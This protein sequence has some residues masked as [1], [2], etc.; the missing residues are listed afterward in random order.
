ME[1]SYLTYLNGV[2]IAELALTD[3]ETLQAIESSLAAQGR[4]SCVI[5]PRVHLAPKAGVDGHFN[6]LRG[7]IGA[8]M[9][10]AGVKVV[11]DF[12]DNYKLGLPSELGMLNLFDPR[13]GV[14]I[15]IV[16]AT[17]ITDMR[18]GAI[19]ALGAKHLARKNSKILG[20]V[21]ARGTAYWNVRLLDK[22]FDFEEI[23]VHSA[24]PESRDAFGARLSKDLGKPVRVCDNWQDTVEG[25]D[26]VVEATRL[27]A[28]EPMLKTEWIKPGAFVVPYGTMSAVELSLTDIMSKMVV[29]DWGQCKGGPFGSL[30]AHVEAGKLSAQTLHAELGQI[31]A[32]LKP[33]R[34]SDD[35][36]ILFWHRG[37]SL[38]DIALG[39]AMLEKAKRMGLGQKLRFH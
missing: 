24:R 6:V 35:E 22:L 16:N 4:G 17:A 5:E 32:G 12:V 21:G 14:P 3:D 30:R 2:D 29:D 23:R 37:L 33:G 13:T 25:A 1:P 9:D 34:E 27:R 36:T 10:L 39:H 11:G 8:P 20:H 7:A 26:I 15:A 38:S 18:T 31:V 28:P 19:T